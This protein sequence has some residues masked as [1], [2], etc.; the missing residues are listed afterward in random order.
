MGGD[1]G[2]KNQSGANPLEGKQLKEVQGKTKTTKHL[3]PCAKSIHLANI[4]T[5][6]RAY[7]AHSL[8]EEH[9]AQ[10]KAN[11]PSMIHPSLPIAT[12]A[13]KAKFLK[14]HTRHLKPL[15]HTQPHG[16]ISE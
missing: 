8:K 14:P 2:F 3:T 12:Q 6:L 7:Q 15:S 13:L 11:A 9:F 10:C 16:L 5:R 4:Y 1:D